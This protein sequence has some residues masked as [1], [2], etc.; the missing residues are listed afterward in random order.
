MTSS[1]CIGKN[2]AKSEPAP[3]AYC[4]LYNNWI[5]LHRSIRLVRLFPQYSVAL[6]PDFL[7]NVLTSF[8]GGPD[9][10]DRLPALLEEAAQRWNL[11]L[12]APFPL[13]YNYVCAA[14]QKKWQ[15]GGL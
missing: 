3:L 4:F 14:I 11:I 5:L 1:A 9:W 7:R 2:M 6:P 8:P 13:S 10:L 15:P 12:G